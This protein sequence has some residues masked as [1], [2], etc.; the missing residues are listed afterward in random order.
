MSRMNCFSLDDA[1]G[2]EIEAFVT[3]SR[4]GMSNSKDGLRLVSRK[5]SHRWPTEYLLDR[6]SH[7]SLCVS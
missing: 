2:A 1:A 3:T 4:T 5:V 6:M 7:I